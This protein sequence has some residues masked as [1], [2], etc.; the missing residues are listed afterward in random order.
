MDYETN[1]GNIKK[2]SRL[3]NLL[4]A[5]KVLPTYLVCKKGQNILHGIRTAP[6]A[7]FLQPSFSEGACTVRHHCCLCRCIA[8]VV[9][10]AYIVRNPES[11]KRN[12]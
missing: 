5:S 11:R 12:F 9:F 1:F 10:T 3:Q 8:V 6:T 2:I 4:G 7:A